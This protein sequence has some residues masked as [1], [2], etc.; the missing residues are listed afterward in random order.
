MTEYEEEPAGGGKGLSKTA[1]VENLSQENLV[2][3]KKEGTQ[4]AKNGVREGMKGW[5]RGIG[6]REEEEGEGGGRLEEGGGGEGME[7]ERGEQRGR[8]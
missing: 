7:G 4:T 3:L 6:E 5:G 1:G 2:E 8:E